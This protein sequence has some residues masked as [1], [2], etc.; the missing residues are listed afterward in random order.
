MSSGEGRPVTYLELIADWSGVEKQNDS[1]LLKELKR[2]SDKVLQS[3]AEVRDFQREK[4]ELVAAR[5]N[6][7]DIITS[8]APKIRKAIRD[9]DRYISVMD[10][11]FD[12]WS[13]D[14]AP[15][16]RG[17][18]A[19]IVELAVNQFPEQ[20]LDGVALAVYRVLL[21][22]KRISKKEISFK[23]VNTNSDPKERPINRLDMRF[24]LVDEPESESDI[25]AIGAKKTAIC[26]LIDSKDEKQVLDTVQVHLLGKVGQG[27]DLMIY[28]IERKE[29][30]ATIKE[31]IKRKKEGGGM[32]A[33]VETS[34]SQLGD[35]EILINKLK[36]ARRAIVIPVGTPNLA[37][38]LGNG[39]NYI[40]EQIKSNPG[41]SLAVLP[42]KPYNANDLGAISKLKPLSDKEGFVST[43][44]DK[45]SFMLDGVLAALNRVLITLDKK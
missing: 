2:T 26:L 5:T 29:G 11:S 32:F 33:S 15:R 38:H 40:Y 44:G 16:L 42:F 36:G 6:V 14:I 21:D 17:D 10:I 24:S 43:S 13:K 9:N 34:T 4:E 7:M 37:V 12:R 3:D 18:E 20:S 31:I 8:M 39:L 30:E 19:S 41:V 1:Q 22:E 45:D 23:V 28:V 27:H 35:P 25:E